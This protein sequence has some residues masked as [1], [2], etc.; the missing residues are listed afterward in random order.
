MGLIHSP[1]F[2][3]SSCEL[4]SP[5]RQDEGDVALFPHERHRPFS[6]GAQAPVA[7]APETFNPPPKGPSGG[8]WQPA[9]QRAG[10]QIAGGTGMPPHL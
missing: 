3:L 7:G 4:E 1:E 5:A 2:D 6:G 8:G 9:T 10:A